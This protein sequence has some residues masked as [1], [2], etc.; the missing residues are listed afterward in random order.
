MEGK[1][2]DEAYV[3]M[4]KEELE[5]ARSMAKMVAE[6]LTTAKQCII[7]WD[8]DQM[9][10]FPSGTSR[11]VELSELVLFAIEQHY[12]I[13]SITIMEYDETGAALHGFIV[14]LSPE[15]GKLH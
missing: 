3:N 10:E 6:A 15:K 1:Q 8:W 14:A 4:L 5:S 11:P 12:R 2:Y 9:F 7:K 13:I